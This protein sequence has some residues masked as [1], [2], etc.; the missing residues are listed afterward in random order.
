MPSSPPEP[1]P[2]ALLCDIAAGIASSVPLWRAVARHAED[3]RPAVRLL[4]TDRYEVWVIGWTTGQGVDFHDHGEAAGA[5]AVVEGELTELRP[6]AGGLQRTTLRPDEVV[7]LPV[8]LVHDVVNVG[9]R[10]ATSI[11]V[12]SP[13]LTT[14]TRYDAVSLEPVATDVVGS[15]APALPAAASAALL[16]PATRS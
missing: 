14:M 2:E 12:Y 15:E 11:H 9:N 4:A 10:R 6:V 5:L 8:G 3:R 7:P 13:P 16:H 1:L